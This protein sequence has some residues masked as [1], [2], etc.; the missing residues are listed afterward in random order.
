VPVCGGAVADVLFPV[1]LAALRW[2]DVDPDDHDTWAVHRENCP[3]VDDGP[4]PWE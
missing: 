3:D 4:G 2:A 1:E